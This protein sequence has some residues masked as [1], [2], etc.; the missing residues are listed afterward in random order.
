MV[1]ADACRPQIPDLL[2]R[3]AR[4]ESVRTAQLDSLEGLA[5]GQ[6]KRYGVLWGET[7]VGYLCVQVW[8]ACHLESFSASAK[9]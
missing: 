8:C 2:L 9:I 7:T 4:A 5:A 6:W 3:E 1:L